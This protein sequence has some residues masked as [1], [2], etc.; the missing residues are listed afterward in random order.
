MERY[1][2]VYGT[3]S[4]GK[5]GGAWVKA[6]G[7]MPTVEYTNNYHQ[8]K[9]HHELILCLP[10]ACEGLAMLDKHVPESSCYSNPPPNLRSL[11]GRR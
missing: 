4:R 1:V 11:Y 9:C 8:F 2:H 10:A 3:V 5:L 7:K 6:P